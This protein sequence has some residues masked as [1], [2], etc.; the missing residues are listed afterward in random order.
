MIWRLRRRR[1]P[2]Q[3]I[4]EACA[5]KCIVV[6]Q[7]RSVARADVH[8]RNQFRRQHRRLARQR[9]QLR[10]A[11]LPVRGIERRI[12]RGAADGIANSL[13]VGARR[14]QAT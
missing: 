12:P 9:M 5:A 13:V 6:L 10:V 14:A 3:C 8:A 2:T 7:R 11:R 4:P 1:A